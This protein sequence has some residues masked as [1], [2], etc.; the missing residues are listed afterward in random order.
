M[1]RISSDKSGFVGCS[2]WKETNEMESVKT[3]IE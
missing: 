1:E 3:G 2:F